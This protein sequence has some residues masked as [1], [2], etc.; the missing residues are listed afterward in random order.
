M[1]LQSNKGDHYEECFKEAV[2]PG[3]KACSQEDIDPNPRK[4]EQRPLI[5]YIPI[6]KLKHKFALCFFCAWGQRNVKPRVFHTDRVALRTA[7]IGREFY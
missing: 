7:M 5:Y 3:N 2:R 6:E 4:S 1:N